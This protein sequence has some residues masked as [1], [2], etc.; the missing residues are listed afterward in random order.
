MRKDDILVLCT[1]NAARSQMAEGFLKHDVGDHFNIYSAGLTP[2]QVHPFAIQVMDEVG[3]DIRNQSSKG[4]NAF[5]GKMTFRYVISVCDQTSAECPRLFP[6]TLHVL[7]WPFD[8]PS[9]F[10]G[11][12][13]EILEKFRSVRDQIRKRIKEW[14]LEIKK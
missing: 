4:L 12:N 6:G 14:L 3:I 9:A 13:E 5:L 8:D 11:T 7:S 10:K 2:T 1:H